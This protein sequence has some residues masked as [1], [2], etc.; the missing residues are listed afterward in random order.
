MGTS[1]FTYRASNGPYSVP[2]ARLM[3]SAG[4]RGVV[5]DERLVTTRPDA[6]AVRPPDLVNRDFTASGPNGLW[7]VDFT[8]VPTWSGTAFTAFVTDAFSR[9]IVGWRTASAMPTE[10]PLDALEMALW[11]RA[12]AGETVEGLVHSP[13]LAPAAQPIQETGAQQEGPDL[14]GLTLQ[15]LLDQVVDDVPVV[16]REAGNEATDVVPSL[17][18]S[19]VSWSAAIQPSVRPSN[20]VMSFAGSSPMT[21]LR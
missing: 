21:S 2:G 7:L 3:R 15:N 12:C 1:T 16:A 8:Y 17:R 6:A 11:T 18:R 10:L 20:A 4:L 9:R 5:R 19:T 14:F 13:T